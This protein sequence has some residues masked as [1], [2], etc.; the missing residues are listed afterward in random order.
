MP[1]ELNVE[2]ELKCERCGKTRKAVMPLICDV[3]PD[4]DDNKWECEL[5]EGAEVPRCE[6]GGKMGLIEKQSQ[7]HYG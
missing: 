6:C 4:G 1:E 5:A 3:T 7:K 2:V